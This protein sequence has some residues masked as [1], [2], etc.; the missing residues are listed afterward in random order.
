MRCKCPKCGS[1]LNL[2]LPPQPTTPARLVR[3]GLPSTVAAFALLLAITF[4]PGLLIG[5][6]AGWSISRAGKEPTPRRVQVEIVPH[7]EY[8][9]EDTD[10]P[11]PQQA[12]DNSRLPRGFV[13][14]TVP[15]VRP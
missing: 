9:E 14:G 6:V 3:F 4:F 11:A 15:S 5:A 1:I 7:E 8:V 10:P 12:Q 13:G 2:T